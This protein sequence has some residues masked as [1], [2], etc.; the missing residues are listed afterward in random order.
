M[1]KNE[2]KNEISMELKTPITQQGFEI[3]CKKLSELEKENA[4]LR[5]IAENQQSSNMERY[6]KN[7]ELEKE[8]GR[9]KKMNAICEALKANKP[10]E[11]LE[12]CSFVENIFIPHEDRIKR[13]EKEAEDYAKETLCLNEADPT[14]QE[15]K[16][17]YITSGRKREKKIDFLVNLLSGFFQGD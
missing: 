1:T 7:K 10:F 12:I 5:A 8:N 6:F 4:E 9:L 13:L 17:A 16:K 14:F 11:V 2:I 15:I 3:I